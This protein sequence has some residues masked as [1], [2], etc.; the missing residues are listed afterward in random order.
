MLSIWSAILHESILGTR[1]TLF[2]FDGFCCCQDFAL[3]NVGARNRVEFQAVQI[4]HLCSVFVPIPYCYPAVG[5]NV[6]KGTF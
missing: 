6:Y 3:I 4:F 1:E 2:R 5:S